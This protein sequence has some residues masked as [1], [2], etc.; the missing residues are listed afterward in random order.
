MI[1]GRDIVC[2]SFVVW[3]EHWGTPQQL[4]SRFAARNRVL[5]VEPPVS[6]LSF[7][8]GIRSP[9]AVWR[10]VRR[11]LAGPRR[12][13][14]NLW[15]ASPPP[16]LPLRSNVVVNR[17]NAAIMRA[18]LARQA[19]RLGFRDPVYWN[20]QP[21][22]PG[23]ARAV[24]PALTV[25]HCVDDFTAM[26]HWWNQARALAS[27]ERESCREAGVVICTA[28]RLAE[29]RRRYHPRVHFVPNAA[30]VELFE[31]ATAPSTEIPPDIASLPK[32]VV[33]IFGVIDFRT[34]VAVLEHLARARPG[35]SLALVGLVKGDVDLSRLRALPNVRIFGKK[36]T[37]ELPGYLRAMDVALICYRLIDYNH[38]VFPLKLYDYLA[39]GKPIV[40]SD[41]E[42]LRPHEGAHLAIARTPDGWVG[43]IERCLRED[44]PEKAAGRQAL[45]RA[46]SWD[47]RVETLSDII[48]PMLR[49]APEAARAAAATGVAGG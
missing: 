48:A 16:V 13:G 2:M 17:I 14:G 5:Y 44:S 10:Q 37:A 6:A 47:H 33:G 29:T 12:L 22:M 23:I 49:T 20:A 41:I 45:A 11:W 32:P 40:A 31:Q 8:T 38:H 18:W 15:V 35:W 36:P 43:A 1:E 28:R 42:E 34:D 9:G 3:D 39:A 26:P 30:N 21:G 27:R 19:T 7:F 25:Y 46:Q 4:M 24:R